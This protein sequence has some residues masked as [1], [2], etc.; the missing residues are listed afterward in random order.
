MGFPVPNPVLAPD[1]V[2]V[3]YVRAGDGLVDDGPRRQIL[4]LTHLEAALS[5]NQSRVVALRDHYVRNGGAKQ[6]KFK[7]RPKISV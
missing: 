2:E 4:A 3:E 6:V 7:F 1:E 5:R